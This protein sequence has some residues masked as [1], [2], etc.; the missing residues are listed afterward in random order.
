M[1]IRVR[2]KHWIQHSSRH[3]LCGKF[4][5]DDESDVFKTEKQ[6]VGELRERKFWRTGKIRKI[7][8]HAIRVI[9]TWIPAVSTTAMPNLCCA[10]LYHVPLGS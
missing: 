10:S 2:V 9:W 4:D 3:M 5:A 6:L 8:F 7:A 1:F